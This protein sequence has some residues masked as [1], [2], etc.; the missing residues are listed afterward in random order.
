MTLVFQTQQSI[1]S[2]QAF[3]NDA[4]S[5]YAYVPSSRD[6]V[7]LEAWLIQLNEMSPEIKDQTVAVVGEGYWPLPWYLRMFN[8]IGYW[9]QPEVN[10]IDAPLVFA[11]PATTQASNT[12]LSDSHITFPRGLRTNVSMTLYLRKDLWTKWI[13]TQP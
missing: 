5:P 11:L 4:R 9:D 3:E 1:A 2:S 7:S 10:M 6:L 8:R 13:D 12:L